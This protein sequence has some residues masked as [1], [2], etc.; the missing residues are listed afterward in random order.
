[1]AKTKSNR[2]QKKRNQTHYRRRQNQQQ[3]ER[4]GGGGATLPKE[5]TGEQILQ[6]YLETY[7]I[8][9]ILSGAYGMT[10]IIKKQT[11]QSVFS[12]IDETLHKVTGTP[13]KNRI[14]NPEAEAPVRACLL[15]ISLI[16]PSPK[17]T[18]K[19]VSKRYGL[20][21]VTQQGFEDEVRAQNEIF[22]MTSG[23]A[24]NHQ[25][26][27]PEIFY[28]D[29]MKHR[30]EQ[31]T[32]TKFLYVLFTKIKEFIDAHPDKSRIKRDNVKHIVQ[33]FTLGKI[34]LSLIG[35]EYAEGYQTAYEVPESAA[36]TAAIRFGFL[37]LTYLTGYSHNDS[38]QGNI[39]LQIASGSLPR[40]SKP[41]YAGYNDLD[42]SD[43]R[44]VLY[45]PLV[46]DFGRSVKLSEHNQTIFNGFF[47]ER[48]YMGALSFLCL[49]DQ[50][51]DGVNNY[52]GFYRN[53]GV[54]CGNYGLK[55]SIYENFLNHHN[56]TSDLQKNKLSEAIG[57]FLRNLTLDHL[58]YVRADTFRYFG[59]P[60]H[61]SSF[62]W[63]KKIHQFLKE[64]KE[65]RFRIMTP[66]DIA[67][68]NASIGY[69]LEKR[70]N[71]L[72]R[73]RQTL[74]RLPLPPPLPPPVAAPALNLT[75]PL[76]SPPPIENKENRTPSDE[77]VRKPP[78]RQPKPTGA[79]EHEKKTR[80]KE[81]RPKETRPKETRPKELKKPPLE[82]L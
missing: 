41:Y 65:M 42:P 1:M 52:V 29:I 71:L 6:E 8:T 14:M 47:E 15:K 75:P 72:L 79:K 58:Q 76:P 61:T 74:P 49:C 17:D 59:S 30:S 77:N 81:T 25:P 21:F 18:E 54:T 62:P 40:G 64:L 56:S 9:A 28:S 7:G 23:P 57:Q 69:L 10:L 50:T 37:Q 67:Q 27:C 3:Q 53:Y 2:R 35:M 12:M 32:K 68:A 63:D 31:N 24:F 43:P 48:N 51:Y 45:R 78:P 36:K 5:I 44:N 33:D 82:L 22:S 60:P 46:I 70:Q 38:H 20:Q 73:K 13:Y 55:P 66:E 19:D 4:D 34:H 26:L 16:S 39:M 80:P 11:P